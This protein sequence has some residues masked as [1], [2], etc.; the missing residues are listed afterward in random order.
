MPYLQIQTNLSIDSDKSQKLIQ[1]ASKS[2]AEMLGK[3]ENYVMVVLQDS[4]QMMFAGDFQPLAYLQLKSLGLPESSTSDFS[5]ILCNLIN[6]QLGIAPER[7]YIEFSSP[8]RH[9]WGWNNK[10]F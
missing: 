8:G 4:T 6:N 2:V 1:N 10:T 7:V 5:N 3:S 9:M